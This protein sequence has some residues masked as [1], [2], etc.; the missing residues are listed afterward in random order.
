MRR[1]TLFSSLVVVVL[2]AGCSACTSAPPAAVSPSGP[3]AREDVQA[4]VPPPSLEAPEG[5]LIAAELSTVG[6]DAITGGPVV[7]LRAL[8]SG[9]V[10]PIW[11]GLAEARAIVQAL[12][13][14]EPQRPQTHDLMASLLRHLGAT[15][16]EV[17]VTDLAEG[18]YYGLLKL[19]TANGETRWIDTRPS[20]GLA[21]ALRAGAE[22][23][24]S[25]QILEDEADFQ[26]Q[27]PEAS[28][29]VVRVLGLTVRSV[30]SDLVA[31]F[32]LPE[33]EGLV[34]VAVSGEAERR[35]LRRGDLIVDVDGETPREPLDLLDAIRDA[36]EGILS[37]TYWRD[38]KEKTVELEIRSQ[39]P[40][41]RLEK[42]KIA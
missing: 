3:P 12:Y 6:W 36:A 14:V 30:T 40:E 34:V 20:D 24:V 35:G 16:E 4:P 19:R 11:I 1:S 7:L 27:A 31:E 41:E 37:L 32:G 29:Q 21:L 28:E 33:R 38:G 17:V 23:R 22:I 5:E 2:L 25:A 42:G 10:L 18:T 26:F 39:S 15:L 9:R 13:G 8:D